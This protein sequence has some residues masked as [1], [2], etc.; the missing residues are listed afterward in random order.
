MKIVGM[1][2]RLEHFLRQKLENRRGRLAKEAEQR[3]ELSGGHLSE[4]RGGARAEGGEDEGDEGPDSVETV[5]VLAT[6]ALAQPA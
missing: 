3:R 4:V 2:E 6:F 1:Q 5:V